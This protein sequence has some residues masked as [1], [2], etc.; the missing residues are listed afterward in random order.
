SDG[1]ITGAIETLQD[2]TEQ[3]KVRALLEQL[4]SHDGLTGIANRRSFDEKLKNEWNRALR[5]SQT[6]SLLMIDIDHF[7]RYNDTYGHQADDC[8]LMQIASALSQVACRP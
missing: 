8:H 1:K 3:R 7:K 5:S 6:L 2:I 4:A